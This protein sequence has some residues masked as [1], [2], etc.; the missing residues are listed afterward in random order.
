MDIRLK[1]RH[2]RPANKKALNDEIGKIAKDSNELEGKLSILAKSRKSLYAAQM[3]RTHFAI[4]LDAWRKLQDSFRNIYSDLR[5][6]VY[7]N[8]DLNSIS[9][10]DSD[11]SLSQIIDLQ[12]RISNSIESDKHIRAS[13]RDANSEIDN[14]YF[15]LIRLESDINDFQLASRLDTFKWIRTGNINDDK[16]CGIPSEAWEWTTHDEFFRAD[17]LSEFVH[18][19]SSYLSRLDRIKSD[20]LD[21]EHNYNI[22]AWKLSDFVLIEYIYEVYNSSNAPRRRQNCIDFLSR[23]PSLGSKKPLAQLLDFFREHDILKTKLEDTLLSWTRAKQELADR[24]QI[25]LEDALEVHRKRNEEKMN[26]EKQRLICQSLA[27]KVQK[28]RKE[29]DELVELECRVKEANRTA[30]KEREKVK[31]EREEKRRQKIKEQIQTRKEIELH[32]RAEL[33]ATERLRLEELRH[34][35][36][37]QRR[38]DTRRLEEQAKARLR[39][40]K[41]HQK[42]VSKEAARHAEETESHL[43]AIRAKVRPMVSADPHRVLADTESWRNYLKAAVESRE[44]SKSQNS[45]KLSNRFIKPITTFTDEQLLHDRR[46]RLAAALFEAGLLNTNYARNILE[47]VPLPR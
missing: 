15:K 4:W 14:E 35:L 16:C 41:I 30:E 29:K 39:E 34:T 5:S 28:W 9:W 20:I 26:V 13:L 42:E 40:L 21:L 43:E 45:L 46:T 23:I 36:D 17:L 33:E 32:K 22:Y 7:S 25:T 18:L 2:L 11:L 47:Q 37:R 31:Q 10:T 44:E 6:S 27:E 24:I 38:Q 3:H 19:D 8:S 1:Y 12:S